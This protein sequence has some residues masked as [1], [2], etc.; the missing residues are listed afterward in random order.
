MVPGNRHIPLQSRNLHWIRLCT[1]IELRIG[2]YTALIQA[3]ISVLHRLTS[4]CICKALSE[5]WSQSAEW[6]HLVMTRLLCTK[7]PFVLYIYRLRQIVESNI[8]ASQLKW[9]VLQLKENCLTAK[10]S[11]CV[12]CSPVHL[13]TSTVLHNHCTNFLW[14]TD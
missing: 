5:Q 13:L 2:D 9:R 8:R 3:A 6:R 11:T 14:L 4:V 12:V 10:K 7:P 1:I